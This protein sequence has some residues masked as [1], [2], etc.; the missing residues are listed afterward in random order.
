[1]SYGRSPRIGP[2]GR[3]LDGGA[4]AQCELW[5]PAAIAGDAAVTA[6]T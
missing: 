1:M 3:H 6:L 4:S 2:L 5:R